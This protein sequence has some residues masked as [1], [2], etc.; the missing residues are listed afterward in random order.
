MLLSHVQGPIARRYGGCRRR[1]AND[2]RQI[3][4]DCWMIMM[5]RTLTDEGDQME[6][7]RWI[8]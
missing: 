7:E 8:Q 4:A 2:Q 1:D 5:M 6:G 3:S